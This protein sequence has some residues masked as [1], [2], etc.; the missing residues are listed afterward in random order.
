[1]EFYGFTPRSRL[2][3]GTAQYP[4]PAVLQKSVEAGGVDVLP[5]G[6]RDGSNGT[7]LIVRGEDPQAQRVATMRDLMP[8]LRDTTRTGSAAF[9]VARPASRAPAR[10]A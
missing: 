3:L 4:S 9:R 5:M 1:M 7:F 6:G 2:F 8:L 10:R